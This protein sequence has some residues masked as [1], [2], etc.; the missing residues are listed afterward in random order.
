MRSVIHRFSLVLAIACLFAIPVDLIFGI[1]ARITSSFH[2]YVP[3]ILVAWGF[4]IINRL[5]RP[6]VVAIHQPPHRYM[7]RIVIHR[8]SLSLLI[9]SLCMLPLGIVVE[10]YEWGQMAESFESASLMYAFIFVVLYDKT[11]PSK[12]T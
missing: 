3:W 12:S 6:R 4:A 11:R 9:V 2:R 7:I 10:V 1:N 5:S 8:A